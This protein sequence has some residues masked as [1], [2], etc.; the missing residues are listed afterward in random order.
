MSRTAWSATAA[1][2]FSLGGL[3]P[4]SAASP[5]RPSTPS[6]VRSG[7]HP[8]SVSGSAAR[9]GPRNTQPLAATSIAVMQLTSSN[10]EGYRYRRERR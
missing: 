7:A 4:V 6:S 5:G 8:P 10:M 3:S 2:N 1:T 9:H